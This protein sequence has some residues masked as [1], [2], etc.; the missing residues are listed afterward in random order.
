MKYFAM[1][2]IAGLALLAINPKSLASDLPSSSPEYK[3][4]YH[5]ISFTGSLSPPKE[6]LKNVLSSL[7]EKA[8]NGDAS[9]AASIYMG[10]VSCSTLR[11][12][13][14]QEKFQAYCGNITSG[15]I[16]SRGRWLALAAKLGNT[17][18]Q[19]SYAAGGVN[20]VIG[21]A[22]KALK[23]PDEVA[24]YREQAKSYYEALALQCNVDAMGAMVSDA[25]RDGLIYG[26]NPE[27][28]YKFTVVLNTLSTHPDLEREHDLEA[29]IDP[30]RVF[31]VRSDAAV[32]VT[33]HCQ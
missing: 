22:L 10:L 29:K 8:E 24:E 17:S 18:A 1:S 27:L 9:A 30:Q 11:S 13:D 20:S 12:P 23:H 4:D 19:Y 2:A 16:D 28:A 7:E 3:E 5:R 15:Q 6:P 26:D 33:E 32:F 14:S 31:G 25:S 21:S